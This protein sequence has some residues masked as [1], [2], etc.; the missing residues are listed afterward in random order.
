MTMKDTGTVSAMESEKIIQTYKDRIS[1]VAELGPH[2]RTITFK[3]QTK[4][5]WKK[6]IRKFGIQIIVALLLAAP[7][8]ARGRD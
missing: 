2:V 4:N 1:G 3:K 6:K 5:T 7:L 8:A